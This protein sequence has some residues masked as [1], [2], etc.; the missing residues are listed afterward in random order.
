M[1]K[2]QSTPSFFGT[3]EFLMK[4]WEAA[5]KSRDNYSNMRLGVL[6][7]SLTILGLVVS[8][9]KDADYPGI[10]GIWSILLLVAFSG[11]RM[12]GAINRVV[13]VFGSQMALLEEE[14][15]EIGFATCWGVHIKKDVNDSAS[16]AF[17]VAIRM[18]NVCV[19]F[20]VAASAAAMVMGAQEGGVVRSR[21]MAVFII[22]AVIAGIWNEIFIFKQVDP[23]RF[24][25]R[26]EKILKE[27]RKTIVES[28]RP[29]APQQALAG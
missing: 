20:L 29:V 15:G 21:L 24:Y 14:L 13:F 3:R 8:L 26:I 7:A 9:G 19:T 2:G 12:L 18:V 1:I 17:L 4:D 28:K 6:G 27:T 5:H 23:R 11:I 10:I 22:A 25:P 16:K